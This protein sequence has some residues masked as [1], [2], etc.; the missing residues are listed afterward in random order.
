VYLPLA[1]NPCG[2]LCEHGWTAAEYPTETVYL[3]PTGEKLEAELGY[4]RYLW[5]LDAPLLDVL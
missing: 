3:T 4:R 2:P 5:R 1:G